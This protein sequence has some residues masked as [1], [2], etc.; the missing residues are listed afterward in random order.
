LVIDLEKNGNS[1]VIPNCRNKLRRCPAVR[2]GP[3]TNRQKALISLTEALSIALRLQES[4]QDLR[5]RMA[6]PPELSLRAYE[7]KELGHLTLTLA[8]I[9]RN[10]KP[11]A[12]RWKRE[13]PETESED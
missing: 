2:T 12:Q 8:D 11:I 5:K 13:R 4:I 7:E 1:S 10:L 3:K 6:A 9:E